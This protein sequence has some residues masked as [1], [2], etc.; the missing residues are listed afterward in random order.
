MTATIVPFPTKHRDGRIRH[1]AGILQ[2][3]R[4]AD[5]D[6][7]WRQTVLVMRR[8]MISARDGR[9]NHR[10]ANSRFRR[11]GVRKTAGSAAPRGSVSGAVD[12]HQSTDKQEH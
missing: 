6:R 7:Y 8:Q 1:V 4:G 12:K 11:R 2:R 5:L 9:R 10:A 3:K